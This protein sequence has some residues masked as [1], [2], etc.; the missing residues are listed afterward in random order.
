M[1]RNRNPFKAKPA[2]WIALFVAMLI[3]A[4]IIIVQQARSVY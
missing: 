3:V 1:T 4:G 2:F